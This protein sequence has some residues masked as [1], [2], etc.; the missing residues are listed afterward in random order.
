MSVK[1]WK[2]STQS[3]ESAPIF[4][5]YCQPNR[6][7]SQFLFHKVCSPCDLCIM[8][9]LLTLLCGI[10]KCRCK[11]WLSTSKCSKTLKS[12]FLT[13][14]ATSKLIRLHCVGKKKSSRK[15]ESWKIYDTANKILLLLVAQ[16][17]GISIIFYT[18]FSSCTP[19][20][21]SWRIRQHSMAAK[22]YGTY[23]GYCLMSSIHILL[24]SANVLR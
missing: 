6:S 19:F 23:L 10:T 20:E 13:L 18:S 1:T 16:K 24:I 17:P 11:F 15:C 22:N 9:L 8:T 5:Q 3:S 7:K 21:T 14:N 12:K 4:F 2:N